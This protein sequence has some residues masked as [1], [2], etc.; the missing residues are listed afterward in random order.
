MDDV[1][2]R[3]S[4]DRVL[5]E[6]VISHLG[7]SPVSSED[8]QTTHVIVTNTSSASLQGSVSPQLAFGSSQ[9]VVYTSNSV[10]TESNNTLV[11][12]STSS[13]HPLVV[14][15]HQSGASMNE[16]LATRVHQSEVDDA[17]NPSG[18]IN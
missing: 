3:T 16:P 8:G 6:A 1:L 17:L 2:S 10:S 13:E 7:L 15:V 5:R 14:Q 11:S 12:Q 9:F 18:G 4:N